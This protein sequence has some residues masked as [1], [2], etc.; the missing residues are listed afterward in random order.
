[1]AGP[2][3][4]SATVFFESVSALA[5]QG[6]HI[7]EDPRLLGKAANSGPPS[8]TLARGEEVPAPAA[9]P[10]SSD[11]G[12]GNTVVKSFISTGDG[13]V[14][15]IDAENLQ[16]VVEDKATARLLQQVLDQLQTKLETGE[17]GENTMIQ[18]DSEDI[19]QI[20]QQL[21]EQLRA[22]GVH[23]EVQDAR[24]LVADTAADD[25]DSADLDWDEDEKD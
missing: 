10:L 8:R 14:Q 15:L 12:A 9:A 5:Q 17:D 1:M 2:P 23:V 25:S 11:T 22:Q 16:D 3:R 21:Q 19:Q 20:T 4:S 24:F 13:N 7:R 6:V 18:M